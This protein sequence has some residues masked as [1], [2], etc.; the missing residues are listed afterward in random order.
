MLEEESDPS[1]GL[2]LITL[3]STAN[4]LELSYL[5]YRNLGMSRCLSPSSCIPGQLQFSSTRT[6]HVGHRRVELESSRARPVLAVNELFS[7]C[8]ASSRGAESMKHCRSL[9]DA[10]HP[11]SRSCVSSGNTTSAAGTISSLQLT[12]C[13]TRS[14]ADGRDATWS[15]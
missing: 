10:V 15:L 12:R 14:A 8:K 4:V 11:C 5:K 1:F 6:V 13:S 3:V 7:M 2:L 9:S